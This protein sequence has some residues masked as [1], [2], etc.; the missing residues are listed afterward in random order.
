MRRALVQSWSALK[1]RDN[2][3]QMIPTT[4]PATPFAIS[5]ETLRDITPETLRDIIKLKLK[6][7]K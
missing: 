3:C 7:S 4:Q 2:S 1:D 5:P 6:R